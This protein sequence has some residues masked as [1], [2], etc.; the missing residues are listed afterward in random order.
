MMYH[1]FMEV[2]QALSQ[3]SEI[4]QALLGT[5]IYRGHR[6]A[7]IATTGAISLTCSLFLAKLSVPLP[8]AWLS[9]G[10]VC[11]LL[12]G[13]EMTYDYL[14]SFGSTQKR[15]ARQVL[16]QFLPA[17]VVGAAMSILWAQETEVLPA[18]WACFYG[19]G[20]FAARPYLGRGI[21]WVAL[22]FVL[23]GLSL[24]SFSGQM[25]F[26]G[27]PFVFGFG[28]FFLAL[29]LHWN[30]PRESAQANSTVGGAP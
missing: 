17:L 15:L 21:G 11:F 2:R 19:L 30:L 25:G 27:M 5:Q 10:V 7:T 14:F 4:R 18:L 29:V 26:T 12:V 16:C 23:S 1:H 6:P 22:F 28:Q 20:L 9:V 13:G 3:I 24:L 8:Q